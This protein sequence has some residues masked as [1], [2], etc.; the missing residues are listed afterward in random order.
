MAQL[1]QR[2]VPAPGFYTYL[3]TGKID[4]D[5]SV[6]V[7]QITD[8]RVCARLACILTPDFSLIR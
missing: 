4:L 7:I 1:L 6:V 8:E 5:L 2:F 3:T